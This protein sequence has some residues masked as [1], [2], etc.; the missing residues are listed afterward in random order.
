MGHSIT[1]LT[2]RPG[3][4]RYWDANLEPGELTNATAVNTVG[5][6]AGKTTP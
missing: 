2:S 5:S 3:P 4:A 1:S 6:G